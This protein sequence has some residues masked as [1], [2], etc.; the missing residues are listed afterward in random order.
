MTT[1]SRDLDG[2]VALVTGAAGGIGG[3][4]AAELASAGAT[5]VGVD[6]AFRDG[7]GDEGKQVP[8]GV[9][10][11]AADLTDPAAV[12]RAV[13]HAASHGSGL[14]IVVN[15]VGA[16]GRRLGDGP[17]DQ[18]PDDAWSFVLSVN[19]G[20]T[21][22]VCRA[23]IPALRDRGR[24]AIVNISS[25]LALHPDRDFAT[26]AYAAAKGGIVSLSRAMAVTYAPEGIRVNTVCPG[27]I[28]TPMS[29]RAG[30][31][32][33]VLARL[34]ELQP[35]TGALGAPAD[36]AAAVRYLASPAAGFVTGA[37]LT[38]DGGWTAR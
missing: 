23:A 20:T 28:D 12:G 32:P 3:A 29:A 14:S 27:L 7:G 5:V 38:V 16:S 19:L 10:P 11:L 31:D 18:I 34:P 15:T 25:V 37:V 4:V 1:V 13:E 6:L 30:S 2:E 8:P 24:G 35:L 26:H 21:F 22:A 36:V 33:A 9:T 17:V